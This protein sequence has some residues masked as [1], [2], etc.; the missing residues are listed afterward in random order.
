MRESRD[1]EE[2]DLLFDKL[3]NRFRKLPSLASTNG[4]K[5]TKREILN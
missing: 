2:T 3:G 1:K 5:V 4:N